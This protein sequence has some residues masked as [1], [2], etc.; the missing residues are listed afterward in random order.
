MDNITLF[1]SLS[2]PTL[3]GDWFKRGLDA[4]FETLVE[5]MRRTSFARACAVGLAGREGYD[6]AAFAARCLPFPQLVPIAGVA[7]KAEAEIER[8]LDEVLDLGFRGIKLHPRFTRFSYDDPR[9]VDTFKAATRRRLVV[10]LCTYFH[11]DVAHYPEADP[12]YAVAHAL[13]AAPGTRLVLVHGGAVELM[14]WMQFARHSRDILFDVS[15]T[16]MRYRGSSLD[17][18]LAWLFRG[19]EDRT[20]IGTDHPEYPHADIRARFEEL[21]AEATP[22][23]ARKIGGLNLAR[24]L[25]VD[26][27]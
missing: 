20:C 24:F 25:G 19:F 9:M 6:H 4:S 1:D 11:D 27:P 18:D 14:R 21:A 16:L 23:A 8:E 7:P 26:F 10:F 15:L 5:N 22:E 2:H 13:K 3:S 12:L 17:A